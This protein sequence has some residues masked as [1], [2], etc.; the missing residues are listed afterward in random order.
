MV[1]AVLYL[2]IEGIIR[3]SNASKIRHILSA[4][5]LPKPLGLALKSPNRGTFC[6]VG[7][8]DRIDSDTE[9]VS[10]GGG[11]NFGRVGV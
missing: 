2:L 8:G 5:Q 7:G 10:G 4:F 6:V 1:F 3:D 11:L 9:D